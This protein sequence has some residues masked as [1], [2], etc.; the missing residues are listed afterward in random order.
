MDLYGEG[1]VYFYTA[2]PRSSAVGAVARSISH[3]TK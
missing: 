2:E 1:E 3:L